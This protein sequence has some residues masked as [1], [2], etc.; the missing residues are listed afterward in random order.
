MHTNNLNVRSESMGSGKK[1]KNMF[2]LDWGVEMWGSE[3]GR[4][5]K[6]VWKKFGGFGLRYVKVEVREQCRDFENK[7]W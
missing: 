4:I 6:E 3:S 1:G 2:C 5:E 7:V